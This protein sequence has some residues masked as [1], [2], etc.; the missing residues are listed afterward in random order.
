MLWLTSFATLIFVNFLWTLDAIEAF[1]MYDFKKVLT[2]K[3]DN[4]ILRDLGPDKRMN[5][6]GK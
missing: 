5:F 2:Y 3:L 4:F 1:E 6:I